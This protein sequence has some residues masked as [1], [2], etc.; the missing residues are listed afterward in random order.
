MV[1]PK[2]AP[3]VLL[4]M[5]DDQRVR[6]AGHVRGGVVAHAGA[7][8]LHRQGTGLGLY[9][10]PRRLRCARRRAA[11]SSRAATT[12][13]PASAWWARSPTAISGPRSRSSGR[14]CGTVG[15]TPEGERLRDVVVRQGSTTRP[16]YQASLGL[17]PFDQWSERHGLRVAS[18]ASSAAI[19]ASGSR[20]CS[21][22]R[23]P[24]H[25]YAG[26]SGLEPHHGDGRRGDRLG[27][28]C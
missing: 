27:D 7:G 16:F 26:Q 19:P 25:P 2:G 6:R 17:A 10:L 12:T 24:S 23:R 5:T 20:T 3:N 18:T 28:G 11:T 21:A 1:P 4:I 15:A 22:T 8:S 14:R 13:W 9:A